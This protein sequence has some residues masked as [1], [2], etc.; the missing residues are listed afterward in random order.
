MENDAGKV[1]GWRDTGCII[2][3]WRKE[4][5]ALFFVCPKRGETR[6]ASCWRCNECPDYAEACAV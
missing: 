5:D 2:Y 3:P 1:E 6:I 4:P